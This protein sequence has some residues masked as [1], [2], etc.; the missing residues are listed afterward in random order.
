MNCSDYFYWTRK[1]CLFAYCCI[2]TNS[3][4]RVDIA[5]THYSQSPVTSAYR[6]AETDR[7]YPVIHYLAP[8]ITWLRSLY[9]ATRA[10]PAR[11]YYIYN[12][13]R[14]ITNCIY[15]VEWD[16]LSCAA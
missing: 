7:L 11:V 12:N 13:F 15:Q 16:I 4:K 14:L 3:L 2:T 10:N 1:E 8:L 5:A 6:A 9:K